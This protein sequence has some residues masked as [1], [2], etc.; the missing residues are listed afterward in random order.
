MMAWYDDGLGTALIF[1]FYATLLFVVVA[2]A[3]SIEASR[4]LLSSN[5]YF[6]NKIYICFMVECIRLRKVRSAGVRLR[7]N[8]WR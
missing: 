8:W 1:I 3:F 7:R 4:S 6:V 2:V 5:D